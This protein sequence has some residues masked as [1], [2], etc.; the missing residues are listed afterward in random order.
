M[1]A[2]LCLKSLVD[3]ATLR[4]AAGFCNLEQPQARA[5]RRMEEHLTIKVPNGQNY[6]EVKMCIKVDSSK[7]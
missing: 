7:Q 2:A 4:V 5:K 1:L 3:A 6:H